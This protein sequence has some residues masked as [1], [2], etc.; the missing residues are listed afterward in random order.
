MQE[1]ISWMDGEYSQ[2]VFN[3]NHWME[4]NLIIRSK[5]YRDHLVVIIFSCQNPML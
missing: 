2:Y 4:Q 5:Y 1:P 3:V